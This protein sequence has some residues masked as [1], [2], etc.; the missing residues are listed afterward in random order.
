MLSEKTITLLTKLANELENKVQDKWL[1]MDHWAQ[2]GWTEQKCGTTA[3]A[4]GWATTLVPETELVLTREG[5]GGCTEYWGPK[6]GN[7]T[8][9]EAVEEAFQLTEDQ[10][11]FLFAPE[12]YFDDY[13]AYDQNDPFPMVKTVVTRIRTFIANNGKTT[14]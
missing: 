1:R 4:I 3:C 11:E 10:A 6:L 2:E 7:R 9:W 14:C 12:S 8:G 13:A 5:G